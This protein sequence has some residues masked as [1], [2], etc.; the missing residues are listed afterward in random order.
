MHI[1]RHIEEKPYTCKIQGCRK[2][3]NKLLDYSQHQKTHTKQVN[4]LT[5]QKYTACSSK[6]FFKVCF[7]KRKI[8]K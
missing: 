2:S 5:Y 8:W 7:K 1:R 4:K 6:D 3:F